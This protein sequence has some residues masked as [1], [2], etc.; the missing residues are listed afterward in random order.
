MVLRLRRFFDIRAGEGL[1]VLVA[2]SY[3]ATVVAAYLLAKPIRTSLF[4]HQYGPYA[5]VYV[6]AA[7]PLA[8]SLF[9][10][11]YNRVVA[12]FGTRAVTVWTL[13]FFSANVVIFWYLFSY[14]PGGLL[15]AIFYVWVGCFGIIAPVQAWSFAH[16]LFDTRQARRLFGLVGAGA[17]LG[18]ISGGLMA[19]VLVRPVGGTVN[20]MLVLAALILA[21]AGIVAVGNSRIRRA[22]LPTRRGRL[23]YPFIDNLRQIS[24]S[25]YL[26]LMAALV[27][28]VAIATQ[29]TNFQMNV[30]AARQFGEDPD[31]L[32]AFFGTVNFFMGTI[33]LLIQLLA[34]G[35]ALRRFGLA[36]TILVL[37]VTLGFGT[38]LVVLLP[39]LWTV[40]FTYA[41][42][43]GFHF[44]IDKASYELLYL[45]LPPA[46]RAPLKNT[47]DIV[48][49]RL[50]DAVGALLLGI[51]TRG[52]WILPGFGFGLRG[53]AAINLVLI[54]AWFA[55]ATRLRGEYVRTIHESVHKYRIDSERSAGG[56][57]DRSA[58][59]AL[60]AKLAAADA[61]D[62]R[63]ALAV[64]ERQPSGRE[65][66]PALRRLLS[67]WEADIRRRAL[68][69]LAAA[70]DPEIAQ[71]ATEMLHDP[72]LEVRTE[73]L[74]Y[75]TR[76]IGTDP[77]TVLEQ[78]GDFEDFSIRAG[79]AAFLASAGPSQ[80]LVA[81]RAI[82]E[83]MVWSEGSEGTRDRAEAA[84]L[85]AL[86]PEFT[87]LLM[88]LAADPDPDVARLAMRSAR[89]LTDPDLLSALFDA[90]ARADVADD[91]ASA[92]AQHGE[93]VID[94]IERRLRDRSTPMEIRRELPVVLVR[95]GT[96]R[97]QQI[98][99]E[100][101]LEADVTLRHRTIAALNKLGDLH[102]GA[103][104]DR[105]VVE[106]LLAAEIAG[107][108][109]SYQ[110]LG[111]L[112]TQLK[113]DDAVIQALETAMEQELERIFR[114]MALVYP[115]SACHDAYVGVRSSNS[116]VRADAIELLDNILSPE[117]RQVLVPLLDPHVTVEQRIAVA[118][119]VVGAPL[120]TA[121][122]AVATL[123]ASEDA[124][125]RSCA[126]YAVGVLQL[127][128]LEGE[129]R[130]IERS[131]DA[132]V[133]DSVHAALRRLAA[134][135]DAAAAE[136]VP[137]VIDMGV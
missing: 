19:R 134:E 1:P 54:G 77:L 57:L 48:V 2:V 71:R 116:S 39:G 100:T 120:E 15:P 106:L 99:T 68:A 43:Q 55:V 59:E 127:H 113:E 47:I 34:V 94:E 98:L 121:E 117:L 28:L 80:N 8:L 21:A 7:V 38:A 133:R 132:T 111:P 78:L 24:T 10:P 119:R 129:L 29:W 30:V 45:P 107:H 35:P 92:L 114:L 37:P 74:L 87:D 5:L 70:G 105:G 65:W 32:T 72:D 31:A 124:W 33:A 67:H 123:L 108:Y 4:L 63:D 58:V 12:R 23:R 128:A 44:S 91:A 62:V 85:L 61:D 112:R 102:G 42:D 56:Q 13:V 66:H 17:S 6:Y 3:I 130:R 88:L 50:A 122:Q 11:A 46:V 76:E 18:A 90:L 83:A 118:N 40:L 22:S 109:R 104:V 64:L 75:V 49:N 41:G 53:T 131:G 101:L 82:L 95:V 9:V 73:A 93:A 110:V 69:M 125:L 86:V 81:A 89:A 14:H 137:A 51:A 84:R 115:G 25:P 97:A 79:M 96:P 135:P 60:A 27:F 16:G 136:P 126:V 20:M 52:F 103:R 26:R 36:I